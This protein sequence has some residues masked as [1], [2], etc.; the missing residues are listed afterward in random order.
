MTRAIRTPAG[1][2]HRRLPKSESVNSGHSWTENKQRAEQGGAV[3]V[4][5]GVEAVTVPRWIC[6]VFGHQP[7]RSSGQHFQ[8][9]AAPQGSACY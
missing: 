8:S 3:A 7:E 6:S 5:A 1:V 4:A 2:A 9:P